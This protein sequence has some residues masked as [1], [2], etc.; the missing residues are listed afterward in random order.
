MQDIEK[1]SKIPEGHHDFPSFLDVARIEMRLPTRLLGEYTNYTAQ[2]LVEDKIVVDDPRRTAAN[3]ATMQ[4]R[5]DRRWGVDDYVLYQEAQFI[6]DNLSDAE[7]ERL[8]QFRKDKTLYFSMFAERYMPIMRIFRENNILG[9]GKIDEQDNISFRIISEH[10]LVVAKTAQM[11]A[12]QMREQL[13]AEKVAREHISAEELQQNRDFLR[14]QAIE[15]VVVGALLHDSTKRLEIEFGQRNHEEQ[16]AE[17]KA[18]FQAGFGSEELFQQTQQNP[19]MAV[20]VYEKFLHQK[21]ASIYQNVTSERDDLS[22]FGNIATIVACT[23]SSG[24]PVILLPTDERGQHLPTLAQRIVFYADHIVQ[25]SGITSLEQ[26]HAYGITFYPAKELIDL[27]YQY[28]DRVANEFIRSMHNPIIADKSKIPDFI[29]DTVTKEIQNVEKRPKTPKVLLFD[30]GGVVVKFNHEITF[31]YLQNLG[32]PRKKAELF[33]RCPEYADFCRG[34]ISSR[35]FYEALMGYFNTPGITYEQV[36]D[37]SFLHAYAVIPETLELIDKLSKK[38]RI[39]ITTDTNDWQTARQQQLV[40]LSRF[41]FFR[42]DEMGVLKTDL[43]TVGS[44][45]KKSSY[46]TQ[47]A[48]TLGVKLNEMLL[49]DDNPT[50]IQMAGTDNV[51]SILFDQME[52]LT[53]LLKER[54]LID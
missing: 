16:L 5:A 33:F 12:I 41:R 13:L 23:M 34:K 46:F 37:A 8:A 51:Q 32:V 38:Y 15:E 36:K 28:V 1:G 42:S 14:A 3:L 47:V 49:V 24:M 40:D 54:K 26:R 53:S 10:C 20:G 21:A 17:I 2:P 43:E 7:R 27:E 50:I 18:L 45:G 6:Y 22:R 25:G 9:V 4:G 31:S 52:N 39:V 11:L 30:I 44:D 19:S 48:K 29:L 35:E